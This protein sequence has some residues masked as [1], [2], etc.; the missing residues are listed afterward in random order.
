M[1]GKNNYDKIAFCY[2]RLSRLV[3]GSSIRQS[4]I[5]LLPFISPGN[6][7]LIVGGGSGWILEEISKLY[8]SGLHIVY[9]EVSAKML[10]LAKEKNIAENKVEFLNCYIEEYHTA[11]AFDIII[12]AFLFDNFTKK[13]ATEN[14]DKLN[15]LLSNK[16]KWLFTDFYI[17]PRSSFYQRM[18]LNLMYYFFKRA[19]NVEADK[20]IDIDFFFLKYHYKEVLCKYYYDRFI[21]AACWVKEMNC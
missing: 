15:A 20:L 6:R 7:I 1:P 13:T 12:T 17:T 14:F 3:F 4:Q 10:K 5:C 2:D 9:I 8:T 11:S 19:G 18:L 21:K 16:G